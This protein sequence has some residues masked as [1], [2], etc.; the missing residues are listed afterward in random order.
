VTSPSQTTNR[1]TLVQ[2][3][4][5]AMC[6]VMLAAFVIFTLQPL[7]QKYTELL[8]RRCLL[9]GQIAAHAVLLPL[10]TELNTEHGWRYLSHFKTAEFA[11]LSPSE[12]A[13]IHTQVETIAKQCNLKLL[14]VSPR[15]SDLSDKRQFL[16]VN[17]MAEGAFVDMQVFLNSLMQL[18][19]FFYLEKFRISEGMGAEQFEVL[20]WLSIE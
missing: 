20:V 5:I 14:H 18:P 9:K 3:L 12:F 8:Q 16:G 17:V 11:P 13:G 7:Y 6:F 1:F 10:H 4:R 2:V 15:V 19:S